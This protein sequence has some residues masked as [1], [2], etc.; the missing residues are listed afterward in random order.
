MWLHLETQLTCADGLAFRRYDDDV[1][2][3]L[4]AVFVPE[5]TW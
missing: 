5:H 2:V 1:L 4:D 3:Q